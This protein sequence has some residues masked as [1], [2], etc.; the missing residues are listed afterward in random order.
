MFS[1][2]QSGQ[3]GHL[4]LRDED[5]TTQN[6]NGWKRVNTLAHYH[7]PDG[8]TMSLVQV[9]NKND[10]VREVHGKKQPP[11]VLTY[12]SEFDEHL[13]LKITIH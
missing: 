12:T 10:M 2:W 8:A 13:T 11:E 7:V 4:P 1:V 5:V 6:D 3:R 9:E